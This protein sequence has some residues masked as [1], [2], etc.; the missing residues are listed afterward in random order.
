VLTPQSDR[1]IK[2]EG[3]KDKTVYRVTAKSVLT[4]VTGIRLEALTTADTPSK[5]PGFAKNGNFVLTEIELYAGPASDPDRMQRIKLKSGV[6]DFDQAGFSAAAAIDNNTGDMGGWAVSDAGGVEH[7]AVFT[8]DQPLTLEPGWVL[9]F[10]LYQNHSA[11]D[12]R[13]ARF[14]LC[15]TGATGDLKIGLSEALSAYLFSEPQKRPDTD[16]EYLKQYVRLVDGGLRKLRNELAETSRPLPEDEQVELLRARI[17]R[18]E[19]VTIDDPQLVQIRSDFQNSKQQLEDARVTAAEDIAWAL[20]NS[21]EFLF[22][23]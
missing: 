7:W 1:S 10:R 19:P 22:N 16:M 13:L 20:I 23:H 14:R 2:A 11:E 4:T 5:G 17:K 15:A 6:T 9:Q 21:P 8:L 12:H 3:N 18:L